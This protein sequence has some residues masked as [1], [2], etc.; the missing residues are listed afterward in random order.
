MIQTF[1]AMILLMTYK[2]L[3]NL[4]TVLFI[5]SGILLVIAAIIGSNDLSKRVGEPTIKEWWLDLWR[6]RHK[7]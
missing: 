2:E 3:V 4:G 1:L 5:A 7:S 6:N